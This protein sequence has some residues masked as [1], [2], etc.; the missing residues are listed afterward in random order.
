[1]PGTVLASKAEDYQVLA[2]FAKMSPSSDSNTPLYISM[3][4]EEVTGTVRLFGAEATLEATDEER[5][6]DSVRLTSCKRRS[7]GEGRLANFVSVSG[8][9]LFLRVEGSVAATAKDL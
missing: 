7:M 1:M 9:F 3:V 2:L 8:D 5:E 6:T 4:A